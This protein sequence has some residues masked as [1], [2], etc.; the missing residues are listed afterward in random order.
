M[1]VDFITN[2]LRPVTFFQSILIALFLFSLK[3]GNGKQNRLLALLLF[4]I[5]VMIGSRILWWHTTSMEIFKP[6]YVVA[7]DFRFFIGPLFYLYLKSIFKPGFKLKTRDLLHSTVF[8]VIVILQFVYKNF[9]LMP[10]KI[11]IVVD[12]LQIT[13]YIL[14][15]FVE[16]K[17]IYLFS[18]S[19]YFKLDHHFIHWLQFFVIS[20]IVNLGILIASWLMSFHVI[21]IQNWNY[22]I[23]RLVGFTNFVL[24]NTIVYV[25]LKIPDLFI[26]I[27]YKNG[28]LPEEIQKRYTT[29]LI[30][31][32]ETN[33]PYLNPLLSLNILA[34][35]I[36]IS[37]K[38]LSQILNNS[39]QQ[40]FYHYINSYRIEEVKKKLSD[41]I[42]K[43]G[44]DN[45][46]EIAYEA[47]FNSKNSFNAAFKKHTGMTPSEF[48][49]RQIS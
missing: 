46:L 32:M 23:L 1:F 22:W 12:T 27:K 45:I 17:L 40:N 36:S 38:H 21:N 34:N 6:L 28:E 15:S 30:Y 18:K 3:K 10:W 31:H 48:R 25:A 13:L 19:D 35:E 39:I 26:S 44:R 5:G 7:L 37:P 24:I 16:F 14:W 4:S 11:F 43:Q 49:K 41:N 2:Y 8:V 42:K 47:G 9:W 29:K 20:N 33:K